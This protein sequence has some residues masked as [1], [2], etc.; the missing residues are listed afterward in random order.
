MNGVSLEGLNA[1]GTLKR[2]FLTVLNDNG[3]SIAHPQGRSRTTST[4][5]A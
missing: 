3:M 2:Q 1:A 5:S 4:T